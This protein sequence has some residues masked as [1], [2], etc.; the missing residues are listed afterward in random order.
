[1][2]E[3]ESAEQQILDLQ[4]TVD[5]DTSDF[6]VEFLVDKFIAD[7][8]YIPPYQR[9]FVWQSKNKSKFIESVLLGIP[10]PVMFFAVDRS[11]G[12]LEIVDGAQRIQ[13]LNEFTRGNFV[14]TNLDKL[15]QLEGLS[16][17]DLPLSRQRKF[18]NRP[19]RVIMLSERSDQDVRFDLFERINTTSMNV[20]ASELRKG[21]FPGMFYELVEACGGDKRFRELCPISQQLAKR[22]EY[23]ELVLRFFCY[24]D[25]YQKFS[26]DV[27]PFLN[28]YL[29]EMNTV[30]TRKIIED[31]HLRFNR[32]AEFV[33]KY[34]P[35]GFGKTI[36]QTPRVR[37]EAI[38]VGV[39]LALKH[40]STLK[41]RQT[42][43]LDS[44]SFDKLTRTDGS[45]SRIRLRD[46]IEFVR[47]SLL[48]SHK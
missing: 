44:D 5:F 18:N 30:A 11:T 3:V 2:A 15:D 1:M 6:T 21:A 32:M 46:R 14:L 42:Q 26:H 9:K 34:L 29:R 38:S 25:R 22:G 28:Q 10:I 24:G 23:E 12:K 35:D 36:K 41:P 37:F 20:N 47:D 7:E 13:T 39:Y 33:S 40:N 45:N 48:A 19:L 16:F 27:R 31:Y 8:F 17:K 43:W 4:A